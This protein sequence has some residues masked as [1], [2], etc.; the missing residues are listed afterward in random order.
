MPGK[1]MGCL[2]HFQKPK[3]WFDCFAHLTGSIQSNVQSVSAFQT[4]SAGL[5]KYFLKI[6]TTNIDFKKIFQVQVFKGRKVHYRRHFFLE[7]KKF[8]SESFISNGKMPVSPSIFIFFSLQIN[9]IVSIP[10]NQK[11]GIRCLEKTS[12]LS[13]QMMRKER[14]SC[15]NSSRIYTVIPNGYMS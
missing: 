2:C 1:N 10:D 9:F 15:Q 12:W 13:Q 7:L 5:L 8:Y 6:E 14:F 11:E 4:L 3:P